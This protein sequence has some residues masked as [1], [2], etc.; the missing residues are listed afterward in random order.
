VY[1][2]WPATYW[3]VIAACAGATVTITANNP[4]N[5]LIKANVPR[6]NFKHI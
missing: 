4:S 6:R 5:G 3:Y 2:A 1:A